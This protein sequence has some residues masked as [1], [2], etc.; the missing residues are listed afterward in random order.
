[1][2]CIPKD[3][4]YDF[5]YHLDHDC[6]TETNVIDSIYNSGKNVIRWQ[7]VEINYIINADTLWIPY[8][9]KGSAPK[10]NLQNIRPTI[11][12]TETDSKAASASIQRIPEAVLATLIKTPAAGPW[13]ATA[14]GAMTK[15]LVSVAME[16]TAVKMTD[17]STNPVVTLAVMRA[18]NGSKLVM[19][20]RMAMN[21]DPHLKDL[22]YYLDEVICPVWTTIEG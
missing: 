8:T 11:L 21:F 13:V 4:Q 14:A 2:N 3:L 1:M 15:T 9:S 5:N 6:N 22:S 20:M 12:Q 10:A 16:L 7:E 17:N 18:L 19:G